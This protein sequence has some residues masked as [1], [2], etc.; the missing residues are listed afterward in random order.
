MGECLEPNR[1]R[2]T[3]L[4]IQ[5]RGGTFASFVRRVGEALSA[6]AR[7]FRRTGEDYTRFNYLG[8]WH[9][10]PSFSVSPSDRDVRSMIEIAEDP[11]VGANFA[12]LVIVRL[13]GGELVGSA[14]VFW[15]DGAYEDAV[16]TMEGIDG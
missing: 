6:L 2:A 13:M 11:E 14:S 12:A 8:E 9:S 7:F 5:S 15:P 4:T 16:L 10:H 1:F 3:D